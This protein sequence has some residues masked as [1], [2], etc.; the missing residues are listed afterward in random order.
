MKKLVE[1]IKESI[2]PN[3]MDSGKIWAEMQQIY[4]PVTSLG[5]GEYNGKMHG[6]IFTYN[7]EE[8]LCN[9]G[10]RNKYPSD[11]TVMIKNGEEC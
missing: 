5:D 2:D 1:F 8:Y 3:E 11:Y 10:L 9:N 6:H 4:K 7:G